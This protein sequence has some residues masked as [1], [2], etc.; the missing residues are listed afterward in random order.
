MFWVP[1][2]N[3]K[4]NQAPRLYDKEY[5]MDQDDQ[6]GEDDKKDID[7]PFFELESIVAATDNF[8]QAHKLGQGGF[9]PVYKVAYYRNNQISSNL[10]SLVI[11]P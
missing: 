1:D 6:F 7:V 8:S 10:E 9:G 4:K 3:I 2:Q 5:L 11:H